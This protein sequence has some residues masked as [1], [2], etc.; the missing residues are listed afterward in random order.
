MIMLVSVGVLL[1]GLV[2][3][4]VFKGYMMQEVHGE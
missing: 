2:G 3:F 4:N 1:G